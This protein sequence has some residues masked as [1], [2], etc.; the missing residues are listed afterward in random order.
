MALTIVQRALKAGRAAI[1]KLDGRVAILSRGAISVPV[2]VTIGETRAE[3]IVEDGIVTTIRVRDFLIDASEYNLGLGPVNP[4]V[5]D[6][7]TLEGKAFQV[8]P[9]DSEP[10]YRISDRDGDTWRVHTKAVN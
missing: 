8:L 1:K 10:E 7:I 3:E 4:M 9:T 5:G 2:N 6:K